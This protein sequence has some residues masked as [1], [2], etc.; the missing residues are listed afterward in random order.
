[1]KR[2]IDALYSTCVPAA[3]H[4]AGEWAY[5]QSMFQALRIWELGKLR[6]VLCLRRRPNE[7]WVDYMK[8]YW[9]HYGPT[10]QE[11]QSTTRADSGYETVFVLLLGKW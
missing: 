11:T 6:R 3:L 5:T 10:A 4:G 1:M 9:C 2:R 7:C 8:T